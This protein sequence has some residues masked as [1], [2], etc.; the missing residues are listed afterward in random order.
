MQARFL[1]CQEGAEEERHSPSQDLG[2]AHGV[3]A[4][5]GGLPGRH[6]A[7]VKGRGRCQGVGWE[8]RGEGLVRSGPRA[9]VLV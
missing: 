1:P 3:E 9:N 7:V 5:D 2:P 4:I 8:A 6:D